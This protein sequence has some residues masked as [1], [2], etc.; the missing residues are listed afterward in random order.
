MRGRTLVLGFVVF[1]VIFLAGLIWTQFFAYYERQTGV[2]ALTFAGE[3][4]P[5]AD[6]DGIDST[7]SPL[8]LRGCLRIDPASVDRLAPPPAPQATPLNAPFWFG[9]FDAGRLTAD[10]ASGAARAYDIGRDQP[11]GFDLM[12]AVYPDGRGYVW[13]QLNERFAD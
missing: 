3:V 4:V 12:L 2:G 11:E 1:V 7:S 9:C 10:L 13:R 5:V 8:K 6:Y